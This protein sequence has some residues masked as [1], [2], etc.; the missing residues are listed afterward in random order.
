MSASGRQMHLRVAFESTHLSRWKT[1]APSTPTRAPAAAAMHHHR[2]RCCH[3]HPLRCWPL[4]PLLPRR[5]Q[6]GSQAAASGAACSSK[7]RAETPAAQRWVALGRQAHCRLQLHLQQPPLPPETWTAPGACASFPHRRRQT[8]APRG[9]RP[10]FGWAP[11]TLTLPAAPP[12]AWPQ[13]A[14]AAQRAAAPS[15]A[16]AGPVQAAQPAP[17]WRGGPAGG[18]KARVWACD[19][20]SSGSGAK[21]S[22]GRMLS[23]GR[24][25]ST[26]AAARCPLE[27]T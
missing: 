24:M 13:P 3:R 5:S 17:L 18:R 19:E 27:P 26:A 21:S 12:A 2:R 25:Q 22:L 16:G 15:A 20:V 6:Q 9:E 4:L 8:E 1:A 11:Q 14:A 10:W 23:K 7:T